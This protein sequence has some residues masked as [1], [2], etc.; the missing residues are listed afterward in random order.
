MKSGLSS[1]W[2]FIPEDTWS[3]YKTPTT[4][5]PLVGETM[6]VDRQRLESAGILAGRRVQTSDMWGAGRTKVGGGVQTELYNKNIATLFGHM[7]GDSSSPYTPGSLDGMGLTMQFGV[8]DVSGTVQPK[9]YTGCKFEGWEL[10]FKEGE[11]ATLGLDVSARREVLVRTV[12]DGVT[13]NTSTTITSA[14]A[15]FTA[16]DVGKPISGTGIAAGATIASIA[17]ATSATLSAAATADGTGITFTIGAALA[18]ASYTSGLKPVKFQQGSI[19]IGGSAVKVKGGNLSGKNGLDTDRFFMGQ[20][21][22]DEPL[23]AELREYTSTLDVEFTDLTQYRR[24][25]NGTEHAMVLTFT[26]A[27]GLSLVITT[28]V[29]FDGKTPQAGGA[30][31]VP[32][33]L[34]MKCIASGADS[35]AISIALTEAS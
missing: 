1:Q 27:A 34:P 31:I 15:V 10:A 6:E 11:I 30:G 18:S 9:A 35:T 29:R 26:D 33:S 7:M 23:E 19:T 5:L 8:P 2:G 25:L 3:V 32:Q 13:T 16:D 22:I 24:Y 14:T 12:T 17:S 4:F 20:D 21:Y 28:N